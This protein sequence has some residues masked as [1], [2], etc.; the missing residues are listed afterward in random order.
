[1]Y[2]VFVMSDGS[3]EGGEARADRSWNAVAV[4]PGTIGDADHIRLVLPAEPAYGRIARIATT[5]LAMRLGIPFPEIE[6]LRLAVDEAVI[7]LLRPEIGAGDLTLSFTVTPDELRIDAAAT[8]APDDGHGDDERAAHRRF[9]AL[10]PDSVDAHAVDL[11]H[12]RVQL[13]KRRR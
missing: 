5:T 2:S 10:L 11:E 7:L 3:L 6:D 9:E 1:V 13:V 4:S 12:H 8:L